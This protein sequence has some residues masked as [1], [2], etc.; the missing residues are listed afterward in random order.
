MTLVRADVWREETILVRL[1]EPVVI[2]HIVAKYLDGVDEEGRGARRSGP[3]PTRCGG[4]AV[5]VVWA[6]DMCEMIFGSGHLEHAEDDGSAGITHVARCG[7]EVPDSAISVTITHLVVVRKRYRGV[8]SPTSIRPFESEPM[9]NVSASR[10]SVV[11]VGVGE[12]VLVPG[13]DQGVLRDTSDGE[14]SVGSLASI[15]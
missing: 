8:F 5:L 7:I 13:A 15:G 4:A 11:V 6:P 3:I 1:A 14:D 10:I 2:A 12:I 9:V